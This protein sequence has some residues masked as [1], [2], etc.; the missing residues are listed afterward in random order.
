MDSGGGSW[1][2][3]DY[4]LPSPGWTRKRRVV[5]LRRALPRDVAMVRTEKVSRQERLA[6]M[7]VMNP[8]KPM[9]W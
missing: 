6:G 8:A 1:H 5:V 9:N 2:G 7:V 4:A 3:V